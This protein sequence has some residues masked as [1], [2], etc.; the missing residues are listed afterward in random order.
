MIDL[1]RIRWSSDG[2]VPV[3][4]Q[5]VEGCVL[6]LA[7]ADRSALERTVRTGR[8]HYWSRSRQRLWQKG[9]TSGHTQQVVSLHLDCDGD[10]I[11]ARVVERGPACHTGA[12]SCF[13]EVDS[14]ILQELRE[15][16]AE[17]SRAPHPDS[18]VGRLL[19]DERHLRRKLGEEAVETALTESSE[20]LV[21]EAADLVFHLGV[22][23]FAE[24]V[25]W[26][27]V[28]AELERRRRS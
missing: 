2:L 8:M 13:G 25:A 6:M 11:L 20:E 14:G 24:G 16:F 26:A 9:E 28:W 17:R 1:E 21:R 5:S 7:Y 19:S 22:L 3:I 27:D 10:A 4:A 23:L 12:R 18:Y 15:L